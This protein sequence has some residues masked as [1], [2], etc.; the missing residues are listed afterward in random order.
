M[1]RKLVWIEMKNFQGYA[2]SE[3]AWVFKPSGIPTG[4]TLDEMKH[5]YEQQ[6]D[7][8]FASHVCAE[9]PRAKNIKG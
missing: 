4:K 8:S 9:H 6:R 7:K 1:R 5:D 3:C 2:C